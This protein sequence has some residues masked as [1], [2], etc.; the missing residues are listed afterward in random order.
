MLHIDR[1]LPHFHL[2]AT[3]RPSTYTPISPSRRTLFQFTR[4][5]A[6]KSAKQMLLVIN[7]GLVY[8][9]RRDYI[10]ARGGT[11][12]GGTALQSREV[13]IVSLEFFTEIILLVVLWP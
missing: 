5:L 7:A 13:S 11:V 3:F 4:I 2:S 6:S 9:I 1:S 10:G 12:G 8:I